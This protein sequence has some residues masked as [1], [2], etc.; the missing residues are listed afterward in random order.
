MIFNKT[1]GRFHVSTSSA[2][3][4]WTEIKT[5]REDCKLYGVHHD[6]LDDLIY[7][8]KKAKESVKGELDGKP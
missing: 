8:L 1:V 7:A 6:E 2:F 5:D 4:C 3:P